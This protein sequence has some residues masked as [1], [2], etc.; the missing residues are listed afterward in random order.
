MQVSSP[1]VQTPLHR[2]TVLVPLRPRNAAEAAALPARLQALAAA[3]AT[4]A[5]LV[6][7]PT[8]VM[9]AGDKIIGYLSLGGMPTVQAWFDSK[10]P[11]AATSLKLIEHGETVLREQGIEQ[12]ALCCAEN[13][14]FT[15]HLERLGFTKLGTTV[16]WHKTFNP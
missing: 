8:H 3:A 10:H 1:D 14:P 7:G 9:L 2:R 16:L 5:H 13:S 4:D 6:L 15:P 12:C 11:H